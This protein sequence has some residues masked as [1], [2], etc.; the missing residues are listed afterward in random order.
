MKNF[1]PFAKF[2]I[3]KNIRKEDRLEL[4]GVGD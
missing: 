1:F 2:L 3:N 4:A